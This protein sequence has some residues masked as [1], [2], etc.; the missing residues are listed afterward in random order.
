MPGV[1]RS[2]I[3]YNLEH[4][5]EYNSCRIWASQSC[6]PPYVADASQSCRPPYVEDDERRHTVGSHSALALRLCLAG[7]NPSSNCR[8]WVLDHLCSNLSQSF[9]FCLITEIQILNLYKCFY[10]FLFCL[11]ISE[12]N[13]L[14]LEVP[15]CNVVVIT[16]A[17]PLLLSH[18]YS[19]LAVSEIFKNCHTCAVTSLCN[20]DGL[21]ILLK[22]CP[23]FT[24]LQQLLT[25]RLWAI[26]TYTC[27]PMFSIDVV[28]SAPGDPCICWW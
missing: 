13:E 12:R 27:S 2:Q 7:C 20:A 26:Y 18:Q 3:A 17:I 24:F 23:V 19:F 4:L 22:L 15:F 16:T 6:R 11:W 8:F 9:R 28:V 21:L 10:L 5:R 14:Q 25:K 1:Q